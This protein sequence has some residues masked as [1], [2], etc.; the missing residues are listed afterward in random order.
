MCAAPPLLSATRARDF[1]D[2]R[3]ISPLFSLF[4]SH[5]A[6]PPPCHCERP[7]LRTRVGVRVRRR[8]INHDFCVKDV[9]ELR[10]PRAPL[11]D[12]RKILLRIL[13]C[14]TR[15]TLFSYAPHA[16]KHELSCSLL[17]SSL[18]SFCVSPPVTIS[19]S[20]RNLHFTLALHGR[21]KT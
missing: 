8:Q 10:P 4:R 11:T 9:G 18:R 14:F 1:N 20:R 13:L 15:T 19:Q 5:R 12:Q 7:S 3:S 17:P 21:A 16:L 6:R 2:P